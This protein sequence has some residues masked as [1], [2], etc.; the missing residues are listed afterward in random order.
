M[1]YRAVGN[2][3]AL[4][5][6]SLPLTEEISLQLLYLLGFK[7]LQVSVSKL[8]SS[9][10]GHSRYCRGV[11]IKE[12]PAILDCS[13]L[14]KW[15]YAQQGIWI[16][17]LSIQQFAYGEEVTGS[18]LEEGDV[19][20]TSGFANFYDADP[21]I[22][23]GHVGMVTENGSVIHAAGSRAGVQEV[24]VESFIGTRT[25]QG[26]RRFSTKETRTFLVPDI[27]PIEWSDDIKWLL[28]QNLNKLDH[29]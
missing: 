3:C 29:P 15:S 19:L 4:D 7:I 17:R 10:V 18:K 12:A 28:L 8:A 13:G 20:F 22:R 25:L 1:Q 9:C 27:Y 21:Q 23:I 16:P 5:L 24:S 11:S 26:V 14:V 6:S 2:R